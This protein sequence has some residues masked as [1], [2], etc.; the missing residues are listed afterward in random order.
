MSSSSGTA[1]S[2][3]AI[4]ASHPGCGSPIFSRRHAS[5]NQCKRSNSG[6][7]ER[8]RAAAIASR[9]PAT[10]SVMSGIAIQAIADHRGEPAQLC[11]HPAREV[12][13]AARIAA[14]ARQHALRRGICRRDIIIEMAAEVGAVRGRRRPVL[15][16][17][18]LKLCRGLHLQELALAT[19]VGLR[20]YV[21]GGGVRG[22]VVRRRPPRHPRVAEDPK[23]GRDWPKSACRAWTG[24]ASSRRRP[25]LTC[26]ARWWRGGGDADGCRGGCLVRGELRRAPSGADQPPRRLPRARLGHQARHP[27]A[28]VRRPC[29]DRGENPGTRRAIKVALDKGD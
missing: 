13:R 17:Q 10:C 12:G 19:F 23:E 26:C 22:E 15:I 5:S 24:C 25:A 18:R 1:A 21:R 11:C 2:R 8:S 7:P 6:L 28:N 27:N 4:S 3:R 29:D 14:S 9:R 16:N 20:V